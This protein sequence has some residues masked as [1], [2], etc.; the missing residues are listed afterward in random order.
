[1]VR[2]SAV[3]LLFHLRFVNLGSIINV[4]NSVTPLGENVQTWMPARCLNFAN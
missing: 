4:E 3:P 1:M 2:C